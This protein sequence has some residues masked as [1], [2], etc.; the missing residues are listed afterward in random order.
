MIFVLFCFQNHY[1]QSILLCSTLAAVQ[2]I[3]LDFNP[4]DAVA[5]NSNEKTLTLK[6]KNADFV[7]SLQISSKSVH[8][9]FTQ[10][11][12]MHCIINIITGDKSIN[13]WTKDYMIN[14]SQNAYEVTC[15]I[16]KAV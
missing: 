16:L 5:K 7:S 11:T 14:G 1:N 12:S 10:V 3:C 4:Q 8:P 2:N 6:K 9:S 13:G 15:N